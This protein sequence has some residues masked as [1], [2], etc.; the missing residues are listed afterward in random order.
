M[1]MTKYQNHPQIM[2]LYFIQEILSMILEETRVEILI[3]ILS[4]VWSVGFLK[5]H[6]QV[7]HS[8]HCRVF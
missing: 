4:S 3:K 5:L 7:Y 6:L 1:F 2:D 8:S